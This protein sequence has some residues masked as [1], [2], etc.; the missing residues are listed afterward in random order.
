MW[1]HAGSQNRARS[2]TLVISKAYEGLFFLKLQ[3]Q[4]CYQRRNKMKNVTDLTGIEAIDFNKIPF[5]RYN[6]KR[7][8]W[9]KKTVSVLFIYRISNA[10]EACYFQWTSFEFVWS[11]FLSLVCLLFLL[12]YFY[13]IALLFAKE[14]EPLQ[15]KI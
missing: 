13:I 3:V 12:I 4:F 2:E 8:K 10:I 14:I 7:K 9:K 1:L 6:E 15:G 5:E 11:V